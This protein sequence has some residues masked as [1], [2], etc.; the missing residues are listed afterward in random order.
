ML[1]A[2]LLSLL[3]SPPAAPRGR[4]AGWNCS[5]SAQRFCRPLPASAA[6]AEREVLAT[7]GAVPQALRPLSDINWTVTTTLLL[8]AWP[9]SSIWSF[10]S[11]NATELLCTAHSH[12]VRV[13]LDAPF[14][15]WWPNNRAS[16]YQKPAR[17]NATMREAMAQ[18]AL[19]VV[20]AHGFDGVNFDL[21]GRFAAELQPDVTALLRTVRTRFKAA[22]PHAQISFWLDLAAQT[23]PAAFNLPAIAASVDLVA[24]MAYD[25][26]SNQSAIAGPELRLGFLHDEMEGIIAA[27]VPPAQLAVGFGWRSTAFT[28]AETD[29]ATEVCTCTDT[30]M[31]D[32]RTVCNAER[33]GYF[34]GVSE[35]AKSIAR[36][37][38]AEQATYFN[39]PNASGGR[40]RQ[41]WLNGPRTLAPRYAWARERGLR[42]VAMWTADGVCC[43]PPWV[44][45]DAAAEAAMWEAV[46][47]HFVAEPS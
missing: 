29:P 12:G 43:W 25:L 36:W 23:R 17:L 38:E 31:Y 42:G 30:V 32:G 26:I 20:F 5:C 14:N 11:P 21:E 39:L 40:L 44:G 9:G 10:E 34:W 16:N 37:S 24:V 4:P 2:A 47:E 18:A 19:D 6:L 15:E 28:C 1:R 35:Q 7:W 45:P 33:H 22:L 41:V 27:G 46:A 8:G 13:V 3:W